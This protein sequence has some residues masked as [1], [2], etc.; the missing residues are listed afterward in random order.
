MILDGVPGIKMLLHYFGSYTLGG[1]VASSGGERVVLH[2]WWRELTMLAKSCYY[3]K[4]NSIENITKLA[5]RK[6]LYILRQYR[7]MVL[8]NGEAFNKSMEM[9]I[10]QMV[11]HFDCSTYNGC[12]V[13]N[14][15]SFLLFRNQRSVA[16]FNK[17]VL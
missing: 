8:G 7:I 17:V 13:S 15:L 10:W 2:S 6:G 9:G 11:S 4:V 5:L 1:S 16:N 14:V 3:E 12:G